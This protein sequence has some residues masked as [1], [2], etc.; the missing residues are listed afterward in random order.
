MTHAVLLLKLGRCAQI[1]SKVVG[2]YDNRV[3]DGVLVFALNNMAA[4][5]ILTVHLFCRNWPLG[6]QN[7]MGQSESQA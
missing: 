6:A 3:S 7:K 1:V 5:V 4:H 2:S